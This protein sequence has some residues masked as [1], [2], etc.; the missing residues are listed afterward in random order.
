[1]LLSALSRVKRAMRS[2][3]AAFSRYSLSLFMRSLLA[4]V[5]TALSVPVTRLLVCSLLKGTRLLSDLLDVNGFNMDLI[6][7]G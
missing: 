7:S 5:L 3:S 1:M 6:V 2:H 4:Q